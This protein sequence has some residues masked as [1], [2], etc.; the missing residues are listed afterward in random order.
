MTPSSSETAVSTVAAGSRSQ[1]LPEADAGETGNGGDDGDE[2]EPA[3]LVQSG[4]P[5][6]ADADDR[7]PDRHRRQH[8][9][10][11]RPVGSSESR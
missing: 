11:R 6:G 1:A 10:E 5:G 8:A 9:D 4:R 3:A 2:Q 7:Q